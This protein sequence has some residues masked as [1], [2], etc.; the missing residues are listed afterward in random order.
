MNEAGTFSHFR[1]NVANLISAHF[2]TCYQK[3]P[4]KLL[5][6]SETSAECL[7]FPDTV[8]PY[9]P[10][11]QKSETEFTAG[12]FKKRSKTHRR[13][14][15]MLF[16]QTKQD[17]MQVS[18]GSLFLKAMNNTKQINGCCQLGSS[19]GICAPCILSCFV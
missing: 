1:L 12:I 9:P 19:R 8:S 17:R 11:T 13:L 15:R 6:P 16:N 14:N 5:G 3:N 10:F 18:E 7:M 2:C 4:K